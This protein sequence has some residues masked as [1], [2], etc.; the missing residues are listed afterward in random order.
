MNEFMFLV[1]I[2]IGFII[3]RVLSIPL[4]NG[5][6]TIANQIVKWLK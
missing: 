5:I 4:I 2:I 3:G 6:E 1:Y